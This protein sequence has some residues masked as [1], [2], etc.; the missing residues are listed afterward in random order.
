M[1]L[2]SVLVRCVHAGADFSGA[3]QSIFP[4][5]GFACTDLCFYFHSSFPNLVLRM[6]SFL[7]AM[8]S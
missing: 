5:R 3:A 8:W 1:D 7:I 2:L 4:A 6:N